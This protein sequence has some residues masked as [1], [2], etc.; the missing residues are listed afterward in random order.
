MLASDARSDDF[1]ERPGATDHGRNLM[2]HGF[3][4]CDSKRFTERR[5]D[6]DRAGAKE[7]VQP[8]RVT[9]DGLVQKAVV[10]HAAGQFGWHMQLNRADNMQCGIAVHRAHF[11][12]R[13]QQQR[14]SLTRKVYP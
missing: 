1:F 9:G 8:C 2:D 11:A 14:T 4:R 6:E 10:N 5:H 12:K 13:L 7:L 3:E